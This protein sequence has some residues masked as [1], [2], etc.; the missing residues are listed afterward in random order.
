MPE[1]S[2]TRASHDDHNQSR[3]TITHDSTNVNF[4]HTVAVEKDTRVPVEKDTWLA[5]E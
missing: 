1:S 3:G 4:D 5:H 2:Q